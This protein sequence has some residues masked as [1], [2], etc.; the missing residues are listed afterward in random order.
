MKKAEWIVK[1]YELLYE[2]Q[3]FRA[4]HDVYVKKF[5]NCLKDYR[6]LVRDY[7]KL[8]ED[9]KKL[10]EQMNKWTLITS[11]KWE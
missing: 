5:N 9:Y 4:W 10:Q 8:E 6:E 3:K 7:L 11:N 2:F 1:Y